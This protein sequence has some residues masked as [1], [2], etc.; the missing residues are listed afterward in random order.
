MNW[1]ELAVLSVKD[2]KKAA[3]ILMGMRLEIAVLWKALLL[4]ALVNTFL[5]V[6]S[7]E[8]IGLRS[9]YPAFFSAPFFN[10]AIMVAGLS[11]MVFALVFTGRMMGGVGT[12][13]D[14]LTLVIWVQIVQA[15]IQILA[16]MALMVVPL[17]ANILTLAGGLIGL[18]MLAHFINESHK[19]NSLGKSVMVM[20]GALLG[21]VI[22][23]SILAIMVG[24]PNVGSNLEL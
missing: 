21:V 13:R 3:G 18:Y 11:L 24:G 20:V 16:Y 6:F 8:I 23:L 2:P 12:V 5:F 9:P 14:I 10:F 15:A 19:F 7:V 1:I 17:V 22:G 4:V